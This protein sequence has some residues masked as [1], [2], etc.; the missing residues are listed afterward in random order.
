M[1]ALKP[2]FVFTPWRLLK[3]F[4]MKQTSII[5]EKKKKC[6][7]SVR[8][9]ITEYEADITFLV[10]NQDCNMWMEHKEHLYILFEF[11]IIVE[12]TFQTMVRSI[13][14]YNCKLRNI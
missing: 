2:Q 9:D 12:W 11:D 3:R 10:S 8:K 13:T 14:N 5:N 6:I 1:F 4:Y 7:F